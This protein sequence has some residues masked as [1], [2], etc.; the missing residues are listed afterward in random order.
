MTEV[1][2]NGAHH[3]WPVQDASLG[4]LCMGK[5]I[6]E[7]AEIS[8]SCHHSLRLFLS[9]SSSFSLLFYNGHACRCYE[10]F[11][12]LL[13][14]PMPSY[15][16]LVLPPLK[17]L[18]F[19]SFGICFPEEPKWCIPYPFLILGSP[20]LKVF[21]LLPWLILSSG[22]FDADILFWM[23]LSLWTVELCFRQKHH[24]TFSL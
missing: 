23:I 22:L 17:S 20:C 11:L 8:Q 21:Q 16:L 13:L 24:L 12:C 1:E 18:L 2:V 15:H 7:L 9:Y 4:S 3:F 10:V 19:L 5:I 14:L 6:V